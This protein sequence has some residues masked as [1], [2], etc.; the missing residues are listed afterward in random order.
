MGIILYELLYSR[1]PFYASTIQQLQPKILHDQVKFHSTSTQIS[2]VLRDLIDGMLQKSEA[3]RFD[4]EQVKN[5]KFF[6]IPDSIPSM[7][8]DAKIEKKIEE[9]Q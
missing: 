5:H 7:I 2:P 4:W 8:N 1:T 6:A 3:K 9:I